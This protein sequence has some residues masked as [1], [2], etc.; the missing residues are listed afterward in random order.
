MRVVIARDTGLSGEEFA[1]LV[2]RWGTRGKYERRESLHMPSLEYF[3]ADFFG[4]S[5]HVCYV[6]MTDAAC[7]D[8]YFFVWGPGGNSEA[9]EDVM[10]SKALD[11][12]RKGGYRADW[13]TLGGESVQ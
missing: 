8:Y 11:F 5:A 12:L 2:F 10:M 13:D 6:D 3:R 1:D 9:I 7:T 4:F